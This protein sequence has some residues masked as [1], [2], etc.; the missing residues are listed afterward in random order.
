MTTEREKML[1][2]ELIG[3][4]GTNVFIQPPFYCD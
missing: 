2:G 4:A 3:V 1:A